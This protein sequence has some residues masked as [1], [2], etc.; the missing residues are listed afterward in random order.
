MSIILI[1]NNYVN[2]RKLNTKEREQRQVHQVLML[3][4]L[5]SQLRQD[6]GNPLYKASQRLPAEVRDRGASN[7]R[8]KIRTPLSM[9]A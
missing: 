6:S 4:V 7:F 3:P 8:T 5:Q 2:I 1:F 9:I